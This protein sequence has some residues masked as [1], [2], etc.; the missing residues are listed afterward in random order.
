M[1][2]ELKYKIP[3]EAVAPDIGST[4]SFLTWRKRTEERKFVLMPDIMTPAT[5]TC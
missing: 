2:I 5:A 4:I 1:E 3:T